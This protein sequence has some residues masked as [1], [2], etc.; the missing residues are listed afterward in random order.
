M[1]K[2]TKDT[3][4]VRI[5]VG[6]ITIDMMDLDRSFRIMTYAAGMIGLIKN[7]GL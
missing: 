1:T 6:W 5:V 3:Q 2:K 4:I 7:S